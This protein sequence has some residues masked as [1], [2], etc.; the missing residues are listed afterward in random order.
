MRTESRKAKT[1]KHIRT[2]LNTQEPLWQRNSFVKTIN[3]QQ[4]ET[5]GLAR[6]ELTKQCACKR[7]EEKRWNRNSFDPASQPHDLQYEMV[8]GLKPRIIL[9]GLNA[10]MQYTKEHGRPKLF[11]CF[12][13]VVGMDAPPLPGR[14]KPITY[15]FANRTAHRSRRYQSHDPLCI[16]YQRCSGKCDNRSRRCK[17]LPCCWGC[18][19]CHRAGRT[20]GAKA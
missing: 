1:N 17:F 12:C 5:N 14:T 13:A 16:L 7:T 9:L 19:C 11:Y 8:M 4:I 10:S 6:K 20:R 15:T 18:P 2:R 3:M